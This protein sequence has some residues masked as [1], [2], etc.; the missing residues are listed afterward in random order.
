MMQKPPKILIIGGGIGG[1]ATA[2]ALHQAGFDVT[3]YERTFELKE[4]GAGKMALEDAIAIAKCLQTQSNI[5]SAFQEY[6]SQRFSRTKSIVEQSLRSGKMGELANLY[7][8]ALRNTLMK[9]MGGAINH[10]FY[11][12][13]AY[14]V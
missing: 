3:V 9:L 11:S 8:V 1:A 6:E 4:V 5:A 7:A 2:L 10:S 13:H 14:R 12:I